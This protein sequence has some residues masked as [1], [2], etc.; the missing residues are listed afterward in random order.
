MPFAI[1]LATRLAGCLPRASLPEN[2][3]PEKYSRSYSYL[4]EMM[5]GSL[6]TLTLSQSDCVVYLYETY[7]RLMK[8]HFVKCYINQALYFDI[9]VTSR[10]EGSYAVFKKQ[11]GTSTKDLKKVMDA[12]SLLLTN[13]VHNHKAAIQIAKIQYPNDL[14]LDIFQNLAAYIIPYALRKIIDQ[15]KLL[16]DQPTALPASIHI[17]T[18]TIGLPCSH[19]ICYE[20]SMDRTSYCSKGMDARRVRAFGRHEHGEVRRYLDNIYRSSKS[21]FGRLRVQLNGYL[22]R[23]L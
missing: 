23:L 10:S 3:S 2:I 1:P 8:T 4:L 9:T 22:Y 7:I 13:Q 14:R 5:T 20:P 6:R 12:I 16:T 15:Y 19:A 18:T 17:F 11:L 21:S